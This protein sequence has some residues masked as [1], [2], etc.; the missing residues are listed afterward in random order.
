M[1]IYLRTQTIRTL[2]ED[3]VDCKTFEDVSDMLD[4]ID[5]LSD[6]KDDALKEAQ[7]NDASTTDCKLTLHIVSNNEASNICPKC[8]KPK[9]M[10]NNIIQLLCECDSEVVVGCHTCK[11]NPHAPFVPEICDECNP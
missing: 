5:L 1:G 8:H 3:K 11:H 4:D 6:A 10:Q 7:G 9:R 2:L